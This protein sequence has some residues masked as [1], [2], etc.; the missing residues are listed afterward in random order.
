[1]L[2]IAFIISSL[3]LLAT[4]AAP[5]QPESK[6]FKIALTKRATIATNYQGSVDPSFLKGHL[7][8][9]TA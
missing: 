1:M 6:G 8:Y 3:Y 7:A 4:T 5:F 2:T 9:T